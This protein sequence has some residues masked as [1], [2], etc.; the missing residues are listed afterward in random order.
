MPVRAGSYTCSYL[1]VPVCAGLYLFVPV[2]TG[3]GSCRFVPISYLYLFLS[4][5]PFSFPEKRVQ[6][7]RKGAGAEHSG[8]Q[9]GFVTRGDARGHGPR[10]G[11]KVHDCHIQDRGGG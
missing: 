8:P 3:T 7:S 10:K 1:F 9:P 5:F 2:R 4:R 6:P 11:N